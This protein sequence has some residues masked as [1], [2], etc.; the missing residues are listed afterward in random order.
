MNRLLAVKLTNRIKKWA[1]SR[2]LPI[3]S[4]LVNKR[5]LFGD[6]GYTYCCGVVTLPTMG[7]DLVFDTEYYP[8]YKNLYVRGLDSNVS[9]FNTSNFAILLEDLDV[10]LDHI[11]EAVKEKSAITCD[12]LADLKLTGLPDLAHNP[13]LATYL[14]DVPNKENNNWTRYRENI[15]HL[16]TK[17]GVARSMHPI[18][19]YYYNDG[20]GLDLWGILHDVMCGDSELGH[21]YY[22]ALIAYHQPLPSETVS[23]CLTYYQDD[24]KRRAGIRT[25]IKIRKYLDK[26]FREAFD[27]DKLCADKEYVIN[28][29][30]SVLTLPMDLD[31]RI[32]DDSN[33]DGWAEA[34]ASEKI[35]S[36]MN[37][38]FRNYGVSTHKTFRCYLTSHFTDGAF[39]SGLSLAVLYTAGE[40]VARSIV[41]EQDGQKYYVRN[42]AD[43]RLAKW[44]ELNGYEHYGCIPEGTHLFT[45][46]PDGGSDNEYICPYV[47]GDSDDGEANARFEH[48]DGHDLWIIDHDGDYTLQT[49]AGCR[50][51]ESGNLCECCDGNRS[52]HYNIPAYNIGGTI[53]LCDGCY[54]RHVHYINCEWQFYNRDIYDSD[55][56]CDD[57]GDWFSPEY[58][59]N[60]N[61]VVVD[62]RIRDRDD[63][64]YCAYLDTWIP[65]SAGISLENA[66]DFVSASWKRYAYD[67][68]VSVEVYERYGDALEYC[69]DYLVHEDFTYRI[70]IDGTYTLV[71][72]EHIQSVIGR[73]GSYVV[74]DP[75][76][77]L[78][79]YDAELYERLVA[80]ATDTR[81]NLVTS[82]ST[83]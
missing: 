43:D 4:K 78:S 33:Y 35:S 56:I 54:T 37:T 25:P 74:I 67:D 23:G 83:V 71:A 82:S 18:S 39:S 53:D 19:G 34:Y 79:E 72:S 59:E 65:K 40:P 29:V 17:Q 57:E 77:A 11:I 46:N 1:D 8:K 55:L 69:Q 26:F 3:E 58:L 20:A 21:T 36:C 14:S 60:N 44:L 28:R 73:Q 51:V 47:D 41:Y 16:L 5:D 38:R 13:I 75:S 68:Y 2:G 50:E 76:D 31:V 45:C 24:R 27:A 81:A 15:S 49:T 7:I 12:G 10:T 48:I 61:Q 52:E 62:G 30:T 42:Y 70:A 63:C 80:L 9:S 6:G 32:Y 22:H 64:F 66:P